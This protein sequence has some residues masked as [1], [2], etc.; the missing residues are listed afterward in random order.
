[1]LKPLTKTVWEEKNSECGPRWSRARKLRTLETPLPF[2]ARQS[3]ASLPHRACDVLQAP[4]L[5]SLLHGRV[6]GR[7]QRLPVGP[8]PEQR[9]VAPV[10]LDVVNQ[11]RR[12]H[13]T[14]SFA[15]H[16][17]RVGE[18]ECLT[19][20]L[21]CVGVTALPRGSLVSSPRSWLSDRH[22]TGLGADAIAQRLQP[23]HLL[24]LRWI[25]AST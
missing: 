16:T 4:G 6:T 25:C 8:I 12:C 13:T 10:R 14:L 11:G 23:R 17:Q 9:H 15:H 7:T 22:S 3:R 20:F 24:L 21:P 1:M 19:R 18:N 5:F 2:V